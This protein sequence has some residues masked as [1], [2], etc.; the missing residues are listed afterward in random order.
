MKMGNNK[1]IRN[2]LT[3]VVALSALGFP[4]HAAFADALGDP[5]ARS[6]GSSSG[7][8]GLAAVE[9]EVKA[10]EITVGSTHTMTF[11]TL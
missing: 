7:N 11:E 3:A 8:G 9:T 1:M 4:C 10:G 6:S 5:A 2:M